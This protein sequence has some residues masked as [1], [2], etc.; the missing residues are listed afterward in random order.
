MGI[1]RLNG[2]GFEPILNKFLVVTPFPA[3]K[4]MM[5]FLENLDLFLIKYF[6]TWYLIL[7]GFSS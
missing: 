5:V 7:L 3:G 2:K 6:L 4:S 1:K